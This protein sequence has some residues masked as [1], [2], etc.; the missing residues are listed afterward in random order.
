MAG[1]DI[2]LLRKA[3]WALAGMAA[4]L[5]L[6]IGTVHG[7]VGGWQAP[8]PRPPA[9]PRDTDMPTLQTA[10]QPDLARLLARQRQRLN[11][12]GWVDERSGIAHI[13]IEQAMALMVHG[14]APGP[15]H[16]P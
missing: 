14:Q 8:S 4:L 9:S 16:Q 13:P 10:P 2:H 7:L 5:A 11:S 1:H 15:E 3:W 6:L 12:T